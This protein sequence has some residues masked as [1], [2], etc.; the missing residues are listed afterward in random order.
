MNC[1]KMIVMCNNESLKN[2]DIE[3]LGF[4]S[5]EALRNNNNTQQWGVEK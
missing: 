2:N 1:W 3:M 5:L 4:N